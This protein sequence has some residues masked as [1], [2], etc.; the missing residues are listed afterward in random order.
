MKM[1]NL[2]L[3]DMN[4]DLDQK[5]KQLTSEILAVKRL[6]IETIT[7]LIESYDDDTGSH[8]KRIE[9]YTYA[10]LDNL[11]D[12]KSN[13]YPKELKE[14]ISFAS[15]LHDTG[16]FLIPKEILNKPAKLS[17]EEFEVMKTH[18]EI[19]GKILIKANKTFK[20]K[21]KKDSYFKIASDIAYYHHEK[22]NGKGYPKGLQGE[23]IPICARIVAIA[24]VYDALRSK[25]SYKVSFSH[26]KSVDIIKNES[27]K[28]FDPKLVDIF[29]KNSEKFN[30]IF[31]QNMENDKDLNS[32]KH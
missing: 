5:V 24:D 18:A 29:L 1:Y 10:I 3:A 7:D 9:L 27:G 2:A 19:G 13:M 11:S 12:E 8:V 20:L 23:N 22:W 31:A 17:E 16:K 14:S 6:S 21:F 15:L 25:R 4:I 26:S 30:T 28:A 32:W